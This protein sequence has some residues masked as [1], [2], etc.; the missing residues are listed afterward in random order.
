MQR[1]TGASWASQQREHGTATHKHTHSHPPVE[2][3]PYD[4]LFRHLGKLLREN[5]LHADEPFEVLR[6][7]IVGDDPVFQPCAFIKPDTWLHL[8][9]PPHTMSDASW[10]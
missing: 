2:N 6:I 10:P 3:K 7:A 5:V 4:V 1:G 9:T 8:S